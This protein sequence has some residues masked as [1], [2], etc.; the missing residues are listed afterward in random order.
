MLNSIDT[1][2]EYVLTGGRNSPVDPERTLQGF[3]KGQ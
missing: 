2:E 1:C 3:P